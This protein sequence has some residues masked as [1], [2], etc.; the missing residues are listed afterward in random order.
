MGTLRAI[1]V[2]AI[3]TP[4][5]LVA[6]PLQW[7]AVKTGS[8]LARTIPVRWHRFVC[9][10]L[11]IRITVHGAPSSQKPLLVT[12]NHASWID[13]TVVS[14]LMPLSFIA[15]SEVANW[16]VFGL[17]AKLQRTIFVDRTRRSK[18][19][20]VAAE[21]AD[22]LNDGD[23]MVLFAE[24][25]SNNG[26]QVLPF[27]SALIGA[28]RQAIDD[29]DHGRVWIQP[30]AIA[31]TRLHGIPMGRRYRPLVAWYGDMEMG[32]HLWALLKE[33]SVDVDVYWGE[34][35]AYDLD[36]DRKVV[37]ASAEKTVRMITAAALSG[38]ADILETAGSEL[39]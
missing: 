37:A 21:I 24:G 20:A 39:S 34:P 18:T 9:G 2:L 32:P 23:A 6:I 8:G 27:R 19:G 15:K 35:I 22:R 12:A 28:A 30:L 26:N 4:V 1:I 33:G 29:G 17:F 5:T 16:P 7:L 25:T 3:L 14:T 36:S 31:Y 10:L 38:R 11:G 13:I